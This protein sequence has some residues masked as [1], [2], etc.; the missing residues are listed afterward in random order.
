MKSLS[1]FWDTL[2]NIL[3]EESKNTIH[4]ITD[5][6]CLNLTKLHWERSVDFCDHSVYICKPYLSYTKQSIILT[7]FKENIKR[8]RENEGERNMRVGVVKW[9]ERSPS[10]LKNRVR[11]ST[12]SIYQEGYFLMLSACGMQSQHTTSLG[13]V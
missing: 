8:V 5:R 4:N 11:I 9:L 12:L 10:D 7:N 6:P 13:S 3:S 1:N 2:D